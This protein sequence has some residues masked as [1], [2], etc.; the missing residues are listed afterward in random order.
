MLLRGSALDDF[1]VVQRRHKEMFDLPP[2]VKDV[3]LNH[4]VR[5]RPLNQQFRSSLFVVWCILVAENEAAHCALGTRAVVDCPAAN[6]DADGSYPSPHCDPLAIKMPRLGDGNL[7]VVANLGS[8]LL[9]R[10]AWLV[11][12]DTRQ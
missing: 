2:V 3:R 8:F 5:K 12:G 6:D 11:G 9:V 4:V 1:G 10:F 7:A